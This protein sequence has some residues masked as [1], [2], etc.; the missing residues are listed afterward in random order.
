MAVKAVFPFINKPFKL[1]KCDQ[2][3]KRNERLDLVQKKSC[4]LA[5]LLKPFRNL[6]LSFSRKKK[7]CKVPPS[8]L[9]F[10]LSNH[11]KFHVVPLDLVQDW[12]STFQLK[13]T[14]V[15]E[16]YVHRWHTLVED[17]HSHQLDAGHDLL[18]VAHQCHPKP[19]DV[20]E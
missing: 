12:V 13:E 5:S 19:L 10:N 8:F 9:F 3:G 20:P 14:S 16:L 15:L 6:L 1:K 4:V 2:K 11:L 17:L 18:L 7:S